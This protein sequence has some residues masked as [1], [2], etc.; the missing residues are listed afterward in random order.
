M[1]K[2]NCK[3]GKRYKKDY[4]QWSKF[5]DNFSLGSG[6]KWGKVLSDIFDLR[7]NVI[8]F[9]IFCMLFGGYWYWRG[10]QSNPIEFKITYEE[11]I[12]LKIPQGIKRLYKPKNSVNWYWIDKKG[13]K[14]AVK[15]RDIEELNKIL[16]PY[17]VEIEPY[18]I[19]GIGIGSKKT[20]MEFGGGTYF[21]KYYLWRLGVHATN[22]GF[23]AGVG[24]RLNQLGLDNTSLNVS[25]GQGWDGSDRMLLAITLNF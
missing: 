8:R 20:D 3:I 19:G 4:F 25:S 11:P 24:Y 23:Y 17:G 18:I 2:F 6:R 9:L 10:K 1:S 14:I 16:K 7:K 5:K 15:G 13:K 22:K 12:E 21:L